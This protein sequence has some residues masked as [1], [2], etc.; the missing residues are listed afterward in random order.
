MTVATQLKQTLVSLKGA[1]ATLRLYEQ[2][3]RQ[4]EVRH[5]Y[6]QALQTVEAVVGDLEV[7]T[8]EIESQEPQ[9]QGS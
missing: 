9:Y 3:S 1:Q 8:R 7:R 6:Q 2:L 5:A 4:Q